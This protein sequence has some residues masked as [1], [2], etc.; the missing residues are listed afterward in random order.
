MRNPL[1]LHSGLGSLLFLSLVPVALSLPV[2]GGNG[3][4]NHGFQN[5]GFQNDGF[6][7][8]GFQNDGFQNHDFQNHNLYQWSPSNLQS[9]VTQQGPNVPQHGLPQQHLSSFGNAPQLTHV[10]QQQ[11]PQHQLPQHQLPQQHLSS[12]GNAPQPAQ[13]APKFSSTSRI[14]SADE[15]DRLFLDSISRDLVRGKSPISPSLPSSH[16]GWDPSSSEA[17]GFLEPGPSYNHAVELRQNAEGA[18]Q[19]QNEPD[20]PLHGGAATAMSSRVS[21][22]GVSSSGRAYKLATYRFKTPEEV[23]YYAQIIQKNVQEP[24]SLVSLKYSASPLEQKFGPER[25]SGSRTTFRSPKNGVFEEINKKLFDNKLI[26]VDP[27]VL[28]RGIWSEHKKSVHQPSRVLSFVDLTPELLPRKAATIKNV[29]MTAHHVRKKLPQEAASVGRDRGKTFYNFWGI[30]EGR[31]S[32]SPKIVEHYGM[33]YLKLP[34][35]EAVDK[36]IKAMT[37]LV[38][39]FH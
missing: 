39:S 7:N 32:D 28:S 13:N 8:H 21:K 30:S 17:R 12:F 9:V 2:G 22:E 19:R 27:S 34:D 3:F 33:G 35:F 15:W 1:S 10:P 6:Q 38:N 37:K 29:R 24:K 14:L 11:L 18:L 20:V 26:N 4:Q 5:D 16:A 23:K 36:H 25:D 31:N